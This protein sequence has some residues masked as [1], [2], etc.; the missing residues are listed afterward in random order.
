MQPSVNDQRREIGGEG[1]ALFGRR[2][3]S[4]RKR[5]SADSDGM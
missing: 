4:Q 3:P 2:D 5:G 1:A